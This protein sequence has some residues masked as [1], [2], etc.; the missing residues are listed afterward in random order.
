MRNCAVVWEV[1]KVL[2]NPLT[3]KVGR[4]RVLR[5]GQR[6]GET[7]NTQLQSLVQGKAGFRSLSSPNRPEE[8]INVV[9]CDGRR[10]GL[11]ISPYSG[12]ARSI[13]KGKLRKTGNHSIGSVCTRRQASFYPGIN[14]SDIMWKQKQNQKN[15]KKQVS[16]QENTARNRTIPHHYSLFRPVHPKALALSATG[17]A[18]LITQPGRNSKER[19][20]TRTQSTGIRSQIEQRQMGSPASAS[21]ISTNSSNKVDKVIPPWC[22]LF[23]CPLQH[24]SV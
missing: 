7:I 21:A 4:S 8:S 2:E 14:R 23:F 10:E 12:R 1:E 24:L 19:P 18:P 9:S 13:N 16:A 17:R 6:E 15:P 11:R 5:W 22:S 3:P 20:E